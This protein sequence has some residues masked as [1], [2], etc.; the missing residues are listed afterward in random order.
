MFTYSVRLERQFLGNWMI[1]LAYVGNKGST[2]TGRTENPAVYIPG[3]STV[4]NTQ[5]TEGLSELRPHL[6]KRIDR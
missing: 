2:N 4:G 1:G 5:Q 6:E 3:A